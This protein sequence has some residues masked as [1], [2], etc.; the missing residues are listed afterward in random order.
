MD[1]RRLLLGALVVLGLS[2]LVN[3]DTC[4]SV[5]ITTS[6]SSSTL[7]TGTSATI[8]STTTASSS[9]C[10]AD[11]R[12]VSTGQST[13][14]SLSVSDPAA[15][16]HQGVTVS[17]SGTTKTFTVTAGTADSYNYYV[18]AGSSQSTAQ[19]LTFVSPSTLTVSGTPASVTTNQS[20]NS[21]TLTITLTNAQASDITTSYALSYSGTYFTIAGDP[22]SSSSTIVSA[23]SSRVLQW[24]VTLAS[25]WSG[26]Q[27]IAF[28]LGSND[29]AFTT[30]VTYP[31]ATA[32]PTATPGS[33][34]TQGNPP[35]GQGTPTPTPP[36]A[37]TP[38][39]TPRPTPTLRSVPEQTPTPAPTPA[40]TVNEQ[41]R[42]Q[43][44]INDLR[45]LIKQG[46]E[47]GID[48]AQAETA[49]KKAEAEYTQGKYGQ[50]L[51]TASNAKIALQQKLSE[52]EVLPFVGAQSRSNVFLFIVITALVL[53]GLLG[54]YKLTARQK[55]GS[56]KEF[57]FKIR[58][59]EKSKK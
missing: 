35:P 58:K 38:T 5:T 26:T 54:Y 15:G 19:S 53:L 9:S 12:L 36:P 40:P 25:S 45:D 32:T 21:F 14:A 16:Y 49:L 1:I 4:S 13:G 47:K 22:T 37:G 24:T 23:S 28:Q 20:G 39:P 27:N 42:A 18:T 51:Q 6:T 52:E 31:S 8:S 2:M 57:D 29:N 3:A 41:Q 7:T 50:A 48:T 56:T 44:Q 59:E 55:V 17:T 10:T 43:A 33:P 34:G 46:K 11:I 30:A